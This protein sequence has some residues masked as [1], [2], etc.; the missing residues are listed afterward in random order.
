MF[1]FRYLLSVSFEWT[2]QGIQCDIMIGKSLRISLLFSLLALNYSTGQHFDHEQKF[3]PSWDSLDKRTLPS[4]YDD[5][6]FGIFIHWGVYSV[7]SIGSE[8]FWKNWKAGSPILTK[9]MKENYPP[10]FS[11]QDFARDFTGEFFDPIKWS[12]LFRDSGARYVVL[13]SKHHDGYALWPSKYSYS[14]NSVDVGPHRDIIGELSNAIRTNTNLTFGLYHSLYEWFHP[15]Y[16]EDKSSNFSSNRFV[17]NKVIPQLWELI[18][19]FKPEIIW[20]DGDWEALDTY[21]SSTVFLSWLYN[22]SSVKNTVVVN[23]RWGSNTLCRH[24]DFYTCSDR[25][26]PG[27]LQPHKWENAMTIDRKSWGFRRNADLKDYISLQELVKELVITVSC[28][29]NLL[30]NVGPTKD[31]IISPI[32]EERL[33]GMGAWLTVN[34]EAIYKTRPW[35]TQ[36]DTLCGDVWYTENRKNEKLYAILLSWPKDNILKLGSVTMIETAPIQLLGYE[37][38]LD[39]K[40]IATDL[41]INLPVSA[42]KGEP[43]WVIVLN[44]YML[45]K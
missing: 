23:D 3:E 10:N 11:Y 16:L 24:G 28:N 38:N 1:Y 32:Y 6:K 13:T 4:W 43:A 18:D 39:W 5:A 33:R 26:N 12:K 44:Q 29:G 35:K 17:T 42:Q 30:M 7:P 27:V 21:W 8:W 19:T 36:N 41:W 40:I 25:Y 37:K 2:K 22:F 31:G 15:L 14:W 20:S 34:G 45:K 9:F